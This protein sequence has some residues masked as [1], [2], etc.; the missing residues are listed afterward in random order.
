MAELVSLDSDSEEEK[1]VTAHVTDAWPWE[2][3]S[4]DEDPDS[5]SL[6]YLAYLKEAKKLK[7]EWQK[8]PRI[9][10]EW[11]CPI[12]LMVMRKP[13]CLGGV[14]QHTFCKECIK[15]WVQQHQT[16]P[17]TNL[18]LQIVELETNERIAR[19]IRDLYVECQK[20][21]NLP[22][23]IQEQPHGFGDC[24][25]SQPLPVNVA[26]NFYKEQLAHLQPEYENI[27]YLWEAVQYASGAV[28]ERLCNLPF[29]SGQSTEEARQSLKESRQQINDLF[30]EVEEK[31]NGDEADQ[32]DARQE[33][34]WL[35]WF[36]NGIGKVL[37]CIVKCVACSFKKLYEA[38][39]WLGSR[40]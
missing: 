6:R 27:A 1:E 11:N 9:K 32:A 35:Q 4:L 38:I 37:K 13:M 12:C 10:D 29:P 36:V 18:R 3:I 15:T 5:Q 20:V 39:C 33:I 26:D 25:I 7:D 31:L 23:E 30:D 34:G 21:R 19:Q 28:W 16:N 8:A 24:D 14:E 2:D 40:G 17:L 22:D